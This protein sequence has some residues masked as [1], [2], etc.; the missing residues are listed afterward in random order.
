MSLSPLYSADGSPLQ[1]SAGN[2]LY[3]DVPAPDPRR[4]VK[5][6]K[7]VRICKVPKE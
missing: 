5:I 6:P 4:T 2:Q 7:E 1:D 3:V